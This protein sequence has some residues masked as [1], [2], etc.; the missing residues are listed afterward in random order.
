MMPMSP[1]SPPHSRWIGGMHGPSAASRRYGPYRPAVPHDVMPQEQ[2][3][4][5]YL[6][7]YERK[8]VPMTPYPSI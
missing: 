1:R 2:R 6:I 4:L 3:A 7:W 5:T 8:P